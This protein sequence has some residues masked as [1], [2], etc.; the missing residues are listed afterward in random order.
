MASS[1]RSDWCSTGTTRYDDVSR[2]RCMGLFLATL[3]YGAYAGWRDATTL[4]TAPL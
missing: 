3:A 4:N 1:A 2:H